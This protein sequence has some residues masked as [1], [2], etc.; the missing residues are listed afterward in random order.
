MKKPCPFRIAMVAA[1]CCA[2]LAAQNAPLAAGYPEQKEGDFVIRDFHFKSGE[3]LP[4]LR[5]HYIS[6]GR[7]QHDSS[8]SISNAVLILHGTTGS[9]RNFLS[10]T[11]A[12]ALF[13]PGQPL[14]ANNFYIILP[15]S[16]GTGGSSK[17]SDGLH[18]RFPHYEYDD[19][20]E[21]QSRLV[22]QGLGIHHLRLVTG[23]SMGGMH[24]WLWGEQ[25]PDFMDALLPLACTPAA[26]AGRNRMWRKTTMDA[27]RNDPQW[28][29]GEYQQQPAAMK[30]VANIFAVVIDG[31][32]HLYQAAPTREAA[33]S[34]LEEMSAGYGH[35]ANDLLYQVDAS[36]NY[37]PAP[38]LER[39]QAPLVAI[40]AADDF[41]NPPELGILEAATKKVKSGRYV[42][43]P[44][45]PESRGHRTV[46]NPNLW[47]QYLA[48]LLQQSAA[49]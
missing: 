34:L 11:F 27:I 16:I 33:D 29:N 20:I 37:N 26:I 9:G 44:I 17:P 46:G 3:S 13:A 49:H 1:F 7:T 4:Q 32:L 24:T 45:G 40:N 38:A 48:E 23:I 15:D 8:G 5:L 21:A 2:T 12:S 35:D 25:H 31:P 14:D 39:V 30:T 19:M 41:I 22:T 10:K 43:L 36:R 6:L 28:K 18:A 42:L 47:K